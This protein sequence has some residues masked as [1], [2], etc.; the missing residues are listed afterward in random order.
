M[1][2]KTYKELQRK[3]DEND[4]PA[5]EAMLRL[6]QMRNKLAG[7]YIARA[8]ERCINADG[9]GKSNILSGVSALLSMKKDAG[10]LGRVLINRAFVWE[11]EACPLSAV[12]PT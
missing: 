7:G 6:R 1:K 3:F 12:L 5:R 10:A 2:A 4:E 11:L 9:L 8:I